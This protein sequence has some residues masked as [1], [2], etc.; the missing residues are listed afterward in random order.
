PM[1]ELRETTPTLT[2]PRERGRESWPE[3][4]QQGEMEAQEGRG[5]DS[6]AGRESGSTLPPLEYIG[7]LLRGYLVAEA[8]RA[9]VL[10]DQ[11]AAHERV[12]FDRI[13]RRLEQRQPSSQLLLIPHVLD[14]TPGQV[15]AFEEH[16]SWLDTLGVA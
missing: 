15:A 16:E 6:Q 8:P 2:L 3:P 7:Q 5:F 12:L 13:V 11:H 14:L 4:P 10:I 9:V 1:L